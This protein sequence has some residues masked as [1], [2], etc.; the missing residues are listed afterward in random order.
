MKI[1]SVLC[2]LLGA[3][4]VFCCACGGETTRERTVT[5]GDISLTIPGHYQDYFNFSDYEEFEFA[6]G[7]GELSVF[8]EHINNADLDGWNPSPY[9][10]AENFVYGNA[11]DSEVEEMEGIVTVYYEFDGE[12]LLWSSLAAFYQCSDGYWVVQCTCPAEVYREM[13]QT[14]LNI[15]ITVETT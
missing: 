3:L 11:I 4:L 8:G 2:L 5:H 14:L 12:E 6:Y 10:L 7:F 15:L 9:E 13:E 1:K